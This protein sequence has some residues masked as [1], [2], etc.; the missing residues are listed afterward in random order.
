MSRRLREPSRNPDDLP[1]LYREAHIPERYWR[2]APCN[3][4]DQALRTRV[5]RVLPHDWLGSGLGFFIH[6]PYNSGKSSIAA[7]FAMDAVQRFERV[8]WLPV[9]DV[10]RTIFRE[11]DFAKAVD[12]RRR[13][14]DVVVLDDLGSERFRLATA[15]GS[16]L[17]EVART[18]YDRNRSLIVTSNRSWRQFCEEYGRE[19]EAFVS[20]VS[21]IVSPFEVVNKQW[22]DSRPQQ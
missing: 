8:T 2:A 11:N 9:R 10:P 20:V 3:I 1:R 17:E 13:T 6:G 7:I 5:E 22:P 19:A 21:R 18:A 15:A 12:D 14:S 4:N 16:A